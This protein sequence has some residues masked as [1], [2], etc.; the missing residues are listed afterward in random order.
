M[1]DI[2]KALCR[3]CCTVDLRSRQK[4]DVL[5][6]LVGLAK[7]AQALR[8]IDEE[9]V[10]EKLWQREKQGS[11]GIGEGLAIPHTAIPGLG[12]F[13]LLLAVSKKG[14]DFDAL[15]GRKVH[16]F[17]L[18]L[19]PEGMPKAHLQ[20]LAQLSHV[21]K[22]ENTRK[23]LAKSKSV[24][25]LCE[26]FLASAELR[27]KPEPKGAP[28]GKLVLIMVEDRE[29]F[30]SIVEYL[31]ELDLR[32]AAIIDGRNFSSVLVQM[33]LF[34]EFLYSARSEECRIIVVITSDEVLSTLV[35]GVERIA[36]SAEEC[37]GIAIAALD[38][39]LVRGR[40]EVV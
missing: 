14:V 18:L 17:A 22:D 15:D 3:D 7:R 33:P 35:A 5:R 28:G 37:C 30:D 32:A 8:D 34:A 29:Y 9:V 19:G 12:D 38:L 2:T 16:I 1:G 25:E 11:T 4:E 10:F 24:E 36:G 31:A 26:R 40:I 23:A 13:V 20:L 39:A 21:L 27:P 6:E